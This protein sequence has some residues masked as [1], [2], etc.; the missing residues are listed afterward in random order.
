MTR[1]VMF[2]LGLTL[3]D[4]HDRPFPFVKEAL[5]AL[6][7]FVVG[8]K[9]LSMCLVSDFKM[10]EA[11]PTPAKIKV[12]FQEYL[13]ISSQPFLVPPIRS[14]WTNTD[15]AAWSASVSPPCER[16]TGYHPTPQMNRCRWSDRARE[17]ESGLGRWTIRS[18]VLN[19]HPGST[20][21]C[22]GVIRREVDRH[23]PSVRAQRRLGSKVGIAVTGCTAARRTSRSEARFYPRPQGWPTQSPG[24][25]PG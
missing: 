7:S 18:P 6:K 20:R 9:P 23:V 12:L 11:P 22:L 4:E 13:Q 21:P 24:R 10:P 16:L 1:V 15:A 2:D 3:L 14:P 25:F 17:G 19:A 8:G 5:T